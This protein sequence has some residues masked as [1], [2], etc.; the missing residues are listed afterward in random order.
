MKH[1]FYTKKN[2]IILISV[3]TL[4]ASSLIIISFMKNPRDI[5]SNWITEKFKVSTRDCDWVGGK[6]DNLENV[7]FYY[8]YNTSCS[9]VKQAT[10]FF[11]YDPQG[12]CNSGGEPEY[13]YYMFF[14]DN[15]KL[16]AVFGNSNMCPNLSCLRVE[17]CYGEQ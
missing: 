10:Y 7:S 5:A 4:V 13:A 9:S 11:T 15:Q 6:F 17:Y 16:L 8:R 3:I 2:I 1:T 12:L 14:T